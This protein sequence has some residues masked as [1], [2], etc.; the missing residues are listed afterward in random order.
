[1][2][3]VDGVDV[4]MVSP[5]G[6][7]V[8]FTNPQ[9]DTATIIASYC[10]FGITLIV[11]V[12]LGP[13]LYTACFI[14][15]QWHI[16]HYMKIPA[17]ILTLA[18]GVLTF[19]CLHKGVLGVHVWEMSLDDAIW[20]KKFILVTILVVTPGTAL[21]R[22]GLC[23]FYCRLAPMLWYLYFIYATAILIVLTFLGAWFGLLFACKPVEAAWNLRLSTGA[24]CIDSY[25]LHILHAGV[26]SG[27]DLILI[28]VTFYN[29]IPLQLSW[30]TKVVPVAFFSTGLLTLGAAVA[31]LAILIAGL[32]NPDTTFVLAQGTV[33][34]ILETSFVIIFGSLPNFRKFIEHFMPRVFENSQSLM[35]RRISCD[36]GPGPEALVLSTIG[37]T[38]MNGEKPASE[39][40]N[41]HS[42]SEALI[43]P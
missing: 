12:F 30:K 5:D 32:K 29:T 26:G 28:F 3:T 2:T 19:I 34:L 4:W 27:A 21:A 15:Q 10:A 39:N 17:C 9:K 43:V 33:C 38:P 23:T 40:S 18:S 35:D 1:M 36:Q 22:L 25:P 8:N 41:Y 16:E 42:S 37:G 13:C 11:P 24:E 7:H 6:S 31:R 20:K 14:R